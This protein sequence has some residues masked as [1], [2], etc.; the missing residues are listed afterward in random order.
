MRLGERTL[1]MG[2]INVTPDSFADGGAHLDPER[3]LDVALALEADGADILDVGGESTRP[4]AEPLSAANERARVIPVLKRLTTRIK[5]PISVD[6]YKADV[7]REALNE[8]AA[9][10]NDVSSLR[11]DPDLARVAAAAGVPLVLM[12]NRGRSRDMYETAAYND[13]VGDIRREL[14][15]TVEQAMA[16]GVSRDQIIVDPGLGFSKR[17]SQTFAALARLDALSALDR[18]VLVGP[19]RKSFLQ[20]ALGNLPPDEREWGTAAAVT[21]AILGGAHI[22]RVHG[23]RE[24]MQVTRVA[25]HVRAYSDDVMSA[26]PAVSYASS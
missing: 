2:I 9:I 18:P 20:D 6:T 14:A 1:V 8:G 12:H 17:A 11:Y 23:V 19:S 25:D 3:A 4:G 21:A 22:V 26:A 24:M 10:I 5:V 13:V 15:S 7:A 16:V